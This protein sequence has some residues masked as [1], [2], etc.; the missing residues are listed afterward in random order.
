MNLIELRGIAPFF[1]ADLVRAG[2]L[3]FF[4]S[5]ALFLPSLSF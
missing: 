5:I 2:L 1:I 3:I 4:P